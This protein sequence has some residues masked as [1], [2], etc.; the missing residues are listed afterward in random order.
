M[1]K[2]SQPIVSFIALCTLGVA[3]FIT[4][5]LSSPPN[6]ISA[7]APAEVFS[8]ERAMQDLAIIAQQPH[9]MGIS[10]AHTDVRNYL[11][12]EI[13]A[14]GL[15]PQVQDTFG[16][17][18]VEPG[19]VTGG[20]VENILVRLPG[21]NPEGAIILI[22]HYDT[23]PANPGAGCSSSGVV[24]IL[25]ILRALKA[26]PP[27]RHDVIILFTDG[28]EP[29]TVGA[30]A[31]VAQHP[32]FTDIKLVINLDQ[33]WI[34]PPYLLGT[35]GGNGLWIDGL[36]HST[37]SLRPAYLSLPYH[38]FPSG[39]T[40]MLPFLLAGVPGADIR[41]SA[42]T[43][44]SHTAAELPGV[45]DPGSIQQGGDQMLALV[46]YLGNQPTLE[47]ELPDQT[48]F[49]VLGRLVH[50][51]TSLA[52]PLGIA[53]GLCFLG[54]LVYGF[55]SKRFTWRGLGMGFLALL[56]SIALSE[57]I[58]SLLWLGVQNLHPE[59]GYNSFRAH[60]SNDYLYAVGFILFVLAVSTSTIALVRKKISSLDLV[61]GV[62]VFWFLGTLASSILLPASSYLVT[63][64]LLPGSLSLL[65]AIAVQT[66]TDSW[67]LT[68]IGFLSSAILGTFLWVPVLYNAFL[69]SS[70]PMVWIVIGAAAVWLGSIFPVLDQI[71]SPKPSLIPIVASLI[72]LGFLVVGHVQVG[73]DSP[74]PWINPIGYWLDA[75][76]K[77]AYWVTFSEEFDE[78]QTTLF[79]EQV[80]LPYPELISVAPRYSVIT[81]VAPMLD[82]DGPHLE[83]L[84]DE[85]IKDHREVTA[86]IRTSMVNRVYIFIPGESSL[87]SIHVPYNGKTELPK[88]QGRDWMLRFDGMSTEGF[89]IRFEFS[90]KGPIE[91]LLVD[92]MTGL[93][94]I[95]GMPTQPQP[96]TMMGPGEFL[97][98]IPTDFTAIYRKYIIQ[99]LEQ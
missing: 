17:R 38:L 29:G 13:Q 49:P 28:E 78:R 67:S 48:F 68:L 84:Q 19:F 61:A 56:L 64:V 53:A 5:L 25:E 57:G 77:T 54:T 72:A 98:G 14:L 95:S 75:N 99:S 8:A 33:F 55:G 59:Y 79:E 27:L 11:L 44:E 92:E 69:G 40:D 65:L 87:L 52:L 34:G 76:E 70:F 10:Q 58:V 37:S 21:T 45:V 91:F 93:P 1:N 94:S 35:S 3:I 43:P 63:W 15:D 82:L 86:R 30:H 20:S 16:V 42:Q 31:F 18:I 73:K 23:T 22:S 80:W 36:A 85:W 96:G 50:Y 12:S 47:K 66:K 97:Q 24:T 88:L 2:L 81:S 41:T 83:V 6:S 62:L 4:L 26:S 71:T 32:W 39:E 51:P 7:N 74:P 89:E 9:P 46:R 90:E 60:V